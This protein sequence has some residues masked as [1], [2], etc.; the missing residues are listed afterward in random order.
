MIDFTPYPNFLEFIKN[1]KFLFPPRDVGCHSLD[2]VGN[3]QL[4]REI[5]GKRRCLFLFQSFQSRRENIFSRNPDPRTRL[6]KGF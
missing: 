2:Y 5:K 6:M 4:Q 3:R 1:R